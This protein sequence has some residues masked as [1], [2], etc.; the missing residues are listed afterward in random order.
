M[1]VE[2]AAAAV[3]VQTLTLL[4]RPLAAAAAVAV[5]EE[6]GE[7][8]RLLQGG[9]AAHG[10]M[11]SADGCFQKL[12]LVQYLALEQSGRRTTYR[13]GSAASLLRSGLAS[14]T[15]SWKGQSL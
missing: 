11:V 7:V 3:V 6:V 15:G 8:E 4:H 14:L 1:A 10:M 9:L 5:G 2:A 13:D 12:C